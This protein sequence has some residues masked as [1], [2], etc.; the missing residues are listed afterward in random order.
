MT[1]RAGFN[2]SATLSSAEVQRASV[3]RAAQARLS[4]FIIRWQ[5]HC[6]QGARA[7]E[8]NRSTLAALRERR[9]NPVVAGVSRAILKKRRRTRLPLPKRRLYC[10]SFDG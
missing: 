4:V 7:I 5:G 2:F 1:S 8:G 6:A 3:K 10:C 9:K